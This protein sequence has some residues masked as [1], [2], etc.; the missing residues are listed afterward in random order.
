MSD[1]FTVNI[2]NVASKLKNARDGAQLSTRAVAVLL[3]TRFSI[4]HSHA[5]VA[6]YEKGRSIPT[7]DVLKAL[8]ALYERPLSW[9]TEPGR[10]FQGIRYRNLKSKVRVSDKHWYESHALRWLEAYSALEARLSK[11]LPET[12]HLK[13][14]AG[15]SDAVAAKS[16]R[17]QLGIPLTGP[18]PS[19]IDCLHR[20]GVR[21][22]ELPTDLA[23]DGFAARFGE[24]YAVVLNPCI[25]NDRCRMNAGHEMVH[26]ASGDCDS[27]AAESRESER[28]AYG[29][30][31]HFLLSD[32]EL[33]EA[34]SGRSLVKMVQYK[35]RFGIS[36]AAMIY[37]AQESG[38]IDIKVAKWLWMEFAS[39]GWRKKEPGYVRPDRATRFEDMLDSALQQKEISWREAES[40]MGVKESDLQE[41]IRLAMGLTIN[42][43]AQEG[44]D[45]E[46]RILRLSD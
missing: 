36:L 12:V 14:E 18:V 38:L 34:F 21:V 24:E 33:K 22:I 9:F 6:N 42:T 32:A 4:S 27:S 43:E 16:I 17:R 30:S 46:P 25:S 8:A 20:I 40:I 39:R 31:S 2:S 3:S 44:E 19:V 35:E 15:D 29:I 28:R 13:I 45:E 23:I 37:R 1:S 7:I 10:I 26:V 41:R 11:P 5:T